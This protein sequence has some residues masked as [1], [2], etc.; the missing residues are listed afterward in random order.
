MVHEPLA[1]KRVVDVV[2]GLHAP[3][4][5]HDKALGG[6]AARAAPPS[7]RDGSDFEDQRA[8]AAVAPHGAGLTEPPKGQKIVH[9]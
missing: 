4:D 3:V 5:V 2:Y 6:S 1:S 7:V 8:S 9:S